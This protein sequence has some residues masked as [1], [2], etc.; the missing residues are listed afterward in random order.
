MTFLR[1]CKPTAF[2]VFV[3]LL[4]VSG[5]LTG[6]GKTERSLIETVPADAKMVMTVN[7]DKILKNAGCRFNDGNITLSGDLMAIR[8]TLDNRAGEMADMLMA[9][10][11]A[12]DITKIIAFITSDN[13]AIVTFA[14]TNHELFNDVIMST[15]PNHDELDG[16]TVYEFKD[17]VVVNGGSQGWMAED[18]EDVT[19]ALEE[20]AKNHFGIYSGIINFI[21]KPE[22][23]LSVAINTPTVI[24]GNK[25]KG[26]KNDNNWTCATTALSDNLLGIEIATMDADGRRSEFNPYISVLD[27]DFLRY[28]PNNTQA[29]MAIGQIKDIDGLY[30][31]ISP[32]LPRD[33]REQ[34]ASILP[35]IKAVDG[36]SA[37]AVNPAAGAG[38]L[39]DISPETWDFTVMAHMPQSSIESLS[40]L[41]SMYAS[42][43]GI[44]TTTDGQQST[45]SLNGININYGNFDG[46]FMASTRD[47]SSDNNNSFTQAFSGKLAAAVID[48][49]YNSETMKAFGLP[50]G[51]YLT[52]SVE[53]TAIKIKFRFNGA[54]EPVLSTIAS[55]VAKNIT[56]H[57]ANEIVAVIDET[58]SDDI[59]PENLEPIEE[60]R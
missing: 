49:P 18:I 55:I 52:T 60:T 41:I 42:A 48:I 17:H 30:R 8:N 22:N 20:S 27:T 35:Y 16:M 43:S 36:T 56:S 11:P 44:R 10:A 37:I 24:S 15:S 14:I 32:I 25:N 1:K 3:T 33:L 53:D 31:I 51:I 12:I 29:A 2:A 38:Y 45:I 46:Y 50:Y 6:C 54:G 9:T 40:S 34:A 26:G 19:E 58:T 47:I 13:D 21:D 5:L 7:L 4:T 28:I 59:I 39:A 23:S 57:D